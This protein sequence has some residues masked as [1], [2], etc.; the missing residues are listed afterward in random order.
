MAE[1]DK[2]DIF[3]EDDIEAELTSDE[4]D[5]EDDEESEAVEELKEEE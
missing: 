5:L 2:K 4:E 1:L 3:P